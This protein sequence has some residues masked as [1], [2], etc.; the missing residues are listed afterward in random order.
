ML[1]YKPSTHE[2]ACWEDPIST[3]NPPYDP[4]FNKPEVSAPAVDIYTAN[5]GNGY[6]HGDGTSV[7]TPMVSGIAAQLIARSAIC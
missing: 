1:W 6:I 4:D 3:W 2:G 5:V 7:A